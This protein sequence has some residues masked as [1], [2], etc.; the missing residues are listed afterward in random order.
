[1]TKM[2]SLRDLSLHHSDWL[3][4]K[5]VRL[6]DACNGVLVESCLAV[7]HRWEAQSYPDPTGEQLR[8]IR[9][10]LNTEAGL[11]IALVWY[12]YSCMPLPSRPERWQSE[13]LS[14]PPAALTL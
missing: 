8:C 3:V 1:M 10:Y 7:S 4:P 5:E 12:S 14:K 9:A 2:P 13:E 11:R 6:S